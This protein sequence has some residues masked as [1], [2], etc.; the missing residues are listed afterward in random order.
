MGLPT[1]LSFGKA[2]QACGNFCGVPLH[3]WSATECTHLLVKPWKYSP[4]A[5]GGTLRKLLI[6]RAPMIRNQ[7]SEVRILSGAPFFQ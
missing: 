5:L 6:P 4:V 2:E 7:R 3:R 1:F